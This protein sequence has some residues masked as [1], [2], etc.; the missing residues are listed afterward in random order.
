MS[1]P[2]I[3]GTQ[4]VYGEKK[5]GRVA[6]VPLGILSV[7]FYHRP[8]ALCQGCGDRRLHGLV[9]GAHWALAA[10]LA[11]AQGCEVP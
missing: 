8:V 9:S 5:K 4:S 1:P 7:S 2:I 3:L 10:A 6:R 11:T